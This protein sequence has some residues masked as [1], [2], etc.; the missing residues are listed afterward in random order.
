MMKRGCIAPISKVK[1][2]YVIGFVPYVVSWKK[3]KRSEA[4]NPL[5]QSRVLFRS[6]DWNLASHQALSA[7]LA[8]TALDV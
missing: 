7:T 1:H 3:I 4:W 6:K 8:G 2:T 5:T